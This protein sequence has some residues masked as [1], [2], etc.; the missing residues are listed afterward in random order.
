MSRSPML[1]VHLLY[2]GPWPAREGREVKGV[3]ESCIVSS[4]VTRGKGAG[5]KSSHNT[6]NFFL[7]RE[8][9]VRNVNNVMYYRATA[10]SV[11]LICAERSAQCKQ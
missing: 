9:Y 4:G 3:G 2:G 5:E 1:T 8:P 10:I 6:G 7:K 11:K